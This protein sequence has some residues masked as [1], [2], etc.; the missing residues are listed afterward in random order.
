MTAANTKTI[1]AGDSLVVTFLVT[2]PLTGLITSLA[3]GTATVTADRLDGGNMLPATVVITGDT[4]TA[5]WAA[6]LFLAGAYRVQCKVTIGG[7]TQTVANCRVN[8][9]VSND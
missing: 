4:I 6:A 1:F 8:V 7:Q 3:G 5:T 9:E 2:F